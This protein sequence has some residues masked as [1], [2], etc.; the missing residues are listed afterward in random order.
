MSHTYNDIQSLSEHG[1]RKGHNGRIVLRLQYVFLPSNVESHPSSTCTSL[2]LCRKKFRV[3][4]LLDGDGLIAIREHILEKSYCILSMVNYEARLNLLVWLPTATAPISIVCSSAILLTVYRWRR[5]NGSR[6]MSTYHRLLSAIAFLDIVFSVALTLGPVPFSIRYWLTLGA[7]DTRN[8]Y[9]TGVHAS[10][11]L[12]KL[13]LLDLLDDLL[14]IGNSI[15][16]QR[17]EPCQVRGTLVAPGGA[18]LPSWNWN[19]GFGLGNL[20]PSIDIPVLGRSV[21]TRLRVRPVC[22]M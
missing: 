13:C 9:A 4:F 22:G 10:S 1:E 11:R 2:K 6:A 21:S 14:R 16:C 18:V 8:M 15:Q 20:Q 5:I 17:R 7:W 12:W 19:P 3:W